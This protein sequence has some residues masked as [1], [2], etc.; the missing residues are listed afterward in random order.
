MSSILNTSQSLRLETNLQQSAEA[1]ESSIKKLSTGLTYERVDEEITARSMASRTQK[2]M[3]LSEVGLENV[4]T[5][6]NTIS[7]A[8]VGMEMIVDLLLDQRVIAMQSCSDTAGDADRAGYDIEFQ[9]KISMLDNL[10]KGLN[11]NGVTFFDGTFSSEANMETADGVYYDFNITDVNQYRLTNC[12]ADNP[13]FATNSIPE[14]VV[15][16]SLFSNNVTKSTVIS[17]LSTLTDG[18]TIALNGV[19]LITFE[20]TPSASAT[21]IATP[22]TDLTLVT[23]STLATYLADMQNTI[24]RVIS[25]TESL[26]GC[27]ARIVSDGKDDTGAYTNSNFSLV[28]TSMSPKDPCTTTMNN[29]IAITDIAGNTDT[30][31]VPKATNKNIIFDQNLNGDIQNIIASFYA[32]DNVSVD[33]VHIAETNTVTFSFALNG[34]VYSSEKI[35]LSESATQ[36]SFNGMGNF[37]P[38]GMEILFKNQS[39]SNNNDC[40][41]VSMVIQDEGALIS[42]NDSAGMS[43]YVQCMNEEMSIALSQSDITILI[44]APSTKSANYN[45]NTISQF[46]QHGNVNNT[47]M[48]GISGDMRILDTVISDSGVEAFLTFTAGAGTGALDEGDVINVGG[49]NLVAGID[50]QIGTDAITQRDNVLKVLQNSNNPLITTASYKKDDITMSGASIKVEILSEREATLPNFTLGS[51]NTAVLVNQSIATTPVQIAETFSVLV[52]E[53]PATVASAEV[54]D[55]T[56]GTLATDKDFITAL[57][58]A[59]DPEAF[60]VINIGGVKVAGYATADGTAATT[61][62]AAAA[63]IDAVGDATLTFP[64][65][66]TGT[67]VNSDVATEI[68][69][70]ITTLSTGVLGAVASAAAA[71]NVVTITSA[72]EGSSGKL[73]ISVDT[74]L[75]KGSSIPLDVAISTPGEDATPTIPEHMQDS[76]FIK[77]S[78]VCTSQFNN[79]LIGNINSATAIL[80]EGNVTEQIENMINLSVLV[81]DSNVLFNGT[82]K[83]QGYDEF[84]ESSH[85]NHAGSVL[86]SGTDIYLTSLDKSV[87]FVLQTIADIDFTSSSIN[88]MQDKVIAFAND[89]Q[90]SLSEFGFS[91]TRNIIGL[92]DTEAYNSVLKGINANNITITSNNFDDLN[93]GNAGQLGKFTVDVENDAIYVNI[94][95][96]KCTLD[97]LSGCPS[98]TDPTQTNYYYDPKNQVISGGA[99]TTLI[100][101]SEESCGI[102]DEIILSINLRNLCCDIDISTPENVQYLEDALNNLFNTADSGGMQFLI[103]PDIERDLLIINFP[104]LTADNVYIDANGVYQPTINVSSKSSAE[105]AIVILDTA[106]DRLLSNQIELRASASQCSNQERILQEKIAAMG[107]VINTLVVLDMGVAVQNLASL[108]VTL[109][110]SVTATIQFLTTRAETTQRLLQQAL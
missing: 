90:A 4:Y 58:T 6:I 80:S 67:E 57:G 85:Y 25:S 10:A 94:N 73:N 44:D 95:G 103:G 105:Q 55:V 13:F 45:L 104:T 56:I 60:I 68:A 46:S 40:V 89:L 61:T 109:E 70:A 30:T 97:L 65:T 9:A 31:N 72:V 37:L 106:I 91:Q 84:S 39:I 5:S 18:N 86:R 3:L 101:K 28:V 107:D 64:I 48:V 108:K 2:D 19:T 1:V 96:Q 83:L 66:A 79:E 41:M 78:K 100:F 50:F 49:A 88:E 62:A 29:A 93:H 71:T 42:G 7:I 34:V 35:A 74:S 82:I 15:S 87:T 8:D 77:P 53:Q 76:T 54:D 63:A 21:S 43:S 17:D 33:G 92:N 23:D 59:D 98:S 16:D 52:P 12:I 75:G 69:A 26:S 14:I 27:S 22:A 51:T 36:K 20:D 38:G 99:D 24:N 11:F 81:G 102:N 47:G 110:A 32:G